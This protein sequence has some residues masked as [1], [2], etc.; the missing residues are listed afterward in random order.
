MKAFCGLSLLYLNVRQKISFTL[1]Q[2]IFESQALRLKL[3]LG[4]GRLVG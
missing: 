2:S 1:T 4:L 3:P